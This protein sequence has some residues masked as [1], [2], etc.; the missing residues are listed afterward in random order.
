MKK[1]TLLLMTLLIASGI[2]FAQEKLADGYQ[3]F[4]Y[5]NGQVSSEGT[6]RNGK[7]DGLWISYHVNGKVKSEGLRRNFE[8]DS[9]WNF[10]D[11]QGYLTNQISYISGKKS[12]FHVRYQ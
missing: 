2:A 12:G 3:K 8:L 4:I 1:G 9:L 6:I 10:Y 7:P 11:E 5:G